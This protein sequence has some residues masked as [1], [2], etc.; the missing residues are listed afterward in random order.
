MPVRMR[1]GKRFVSGMVAISSPKSCMLPW[2]GRSSPSQSLS[3]TLLPTPAG[4]RRMR[5]SPGA[6]ENVMSSRTGGPSKAMG[7]LRKAN[8]GSD[9]NEQDA[10][11]DAGG[12]EENARLSRRQGKCD[13]LQNRRSVE[14][15]GDIAKGQHWFLT[16][17]P[18][19]R[20]GWVRQSVSCGDRHMA[21]KSASSNLVRRKSTRMMSTEELTTA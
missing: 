11:A 14:G 12:A 15:D 9:R 4:P 7:T 6:R 3:R 1:R 17:W 13:V 8:T 5:V 10:L 18:R 21:G 20:F 16:G 19:V 2:S